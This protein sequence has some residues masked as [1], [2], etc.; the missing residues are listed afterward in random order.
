M[1]ASDNGR[2]LI[3]DDGTPFL[4][5][6]DT[7]WALFYNVSLQDAEHYLRVRADQGFTV[8]MP[9]L[10]WDAE[11]KGGPVLALLAVDGKGP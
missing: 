4:Y 6:A 2:Y 3:Q 8:I 9:V 10:V 7:A 5:P 1:H 11:G